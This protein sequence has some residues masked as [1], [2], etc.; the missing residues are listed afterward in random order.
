MEGEQEDDDHTYIP[1]E[2]SKNK[3]R[4]RSVSPLRTTDGA[5]HVNSQLHVAVLLYFNRLGK[6]W[7]IQ[8]GQQSSGSIQKRREVQ[9][10]GNP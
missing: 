4:S 8:T 6:L 1:G 9:H 7:R 3:H 10:F 5:S 2:E